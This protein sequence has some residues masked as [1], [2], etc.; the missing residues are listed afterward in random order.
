E[1][2]RV[3]F[4]SELS[5]ASNRT[6]AL[7]G[8][9]CEADLGARLTIESTEAAQFVFSAVRGMRLLLVDSRAR[10]DVGGIY[11]ADSPNARRR[12]GTAIRQRRGIR[13][14]VVVPG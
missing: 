14:P 11:A 2:R 13:A 6:C 5:R 8:S 9:R 3:L 7:R 10:V 1:F 4:R 12:Y